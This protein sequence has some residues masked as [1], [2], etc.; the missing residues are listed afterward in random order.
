MKFRWIFFCFYSLVCLFLISYLGTYSIPVLCWNFSFLHF[1]TGS[2]K[3][4][5]VLPPWFVLF[6]R[7]TFNA[8]ETW[9]VGW[10]HMARRRRQNMGYACVPYNICTVCEIYVIYTITTSNKY[11]RCVFWIWTG[12]VACDETFRKIYQKKKGVQLIYFNF[13]LAD[14]AAQKKKFLFRLTFRIIQF[15]YLISL[16][17]RVCGEFDF[18]L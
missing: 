14:H 10:G 6:R 18:R 16:V 17:F 9:R 13:I 8:A 3:C 4:S 15:Y 1:V 11:L 2:I 7:P 12:V 5:L